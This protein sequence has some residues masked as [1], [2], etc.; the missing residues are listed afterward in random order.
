MK[1]SQ[2]ELL[3]ELCLENAR[4]AE[5]EQFLIENR[6]ETWDGEYIDGFMTFTGVE[7]EDQA[8]VFMDRAIGEATGEKV[9]WQAAAN[10]IQEYFLD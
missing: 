2:L 3:W 4:R 1:Q 8:A 10:L 7:D 9:A 5:T 6:Y